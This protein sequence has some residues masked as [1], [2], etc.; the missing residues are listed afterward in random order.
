[1]GTAFNVKAYPD[2]KTTETSLIRG[3][4]EVT[5][6]KRPGE[7]IIL[8][9][10]EKLV[11]AN[12]D[13]KAETKMDPAKKDPKVAISELTHINDTTIVET[14]WVHNELIF[15]DETFS[16][17][18]KKME[19]WY[20]VTIIIEDEKIALERLSGTLTTETVQEALNALQY[21]E[22]FHYSIKGNTIL[23]TQ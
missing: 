4:V 13:E 14:S 1:L 6:D 23:I 7:H 8:K 15:R 19:R 5:L 16:D 18:A 3:S 9:P 17:I 22:K 20:G 11:V 21:S 12:E 10:N 2:E